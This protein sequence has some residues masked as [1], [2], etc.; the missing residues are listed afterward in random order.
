MQ[1]L[2]K[3]LLLFLLYISIINVAHANISI[4][5]IFSSNMVLQQKSKVKIW[6]WAKPGEPVKL[7]AGW[8]EQNIETKANSQGTWSLMLKTPAAGGPHTIRLKGFNEIVLKNVMVGEVWLV[9][10]QSNMEWSANAGLV[11]KDQEIANANYPEIRFFTV[12]H[13]TALYPQN[14]CDGEWT[15]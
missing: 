9:S 4:P 15:V 12:N 2:L 10:G 7:E 3:T 13:S 14:N 1:K 5:E 6:G 8:L 11:N